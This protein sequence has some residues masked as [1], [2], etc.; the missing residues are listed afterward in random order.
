MGRSVSVLNARGHRRG[1]HGRDAV[2]VLVI[3]PVLNARGHRRGSHDVD[4]EYGN[5][6]VRCSTPEGIEGG[7]TM[8]RRPFFFPR[9]G[10]QRPRASKG[11]ALRSSRSRI[12]MPVCAQRPRASKGV[13]Q[14]DSSPSTMLVRCST[15]EG[16]EG[17]RTVRLRNRLA[18]DRV[19][20]ARGHRRGSHPNATPYWKEVGGCSTPE[21]IEGGRTACRRRA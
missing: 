19:L 2:A 12:C 10:A 1:S 7:R 15:P 21:G 5:L 9:P 20:N 6:R 14:R 13:A 17:G 16:I 4:E 8:G 11:V 3:P 18:D